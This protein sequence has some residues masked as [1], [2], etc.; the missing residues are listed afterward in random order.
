MSDTVTQLSVIAI[1]TGRKIKWD[2]RKEVIVGDAGA[3]QLLRRAM[4]SPWHL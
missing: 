3:S 2:N 4:R 1:L